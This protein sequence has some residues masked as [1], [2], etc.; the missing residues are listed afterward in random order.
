RLLAVGLRQVQRR[1]ATTTC[2]KCDRTPSQP[3]Q[4]DEG[5]RV[6]STKDF[7]DRQSLPLYF[8]DQS[9]Y[10]SHTS[11]EPQPRS[12]ALWLTLEAGS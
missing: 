3:E 12:P 4:H 7:L 2:R 6:Y 10:H 11:L 9:K 5:Q 8:S 1:P